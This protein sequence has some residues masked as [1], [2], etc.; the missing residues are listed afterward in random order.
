MP[1]GYRVVLSAD[2]I[3][4]R[5]VKS[6]QHRDRYCVDCTHC[7]KG[8]KS[9]TAYYQRDVCELRPKAP[10]CALPDDRQCYYAVQRY[11]AAC[12]KFNPR[13]ITNR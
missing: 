2:S 3:E 1:D 6:R 8:W 4:I 11:D 12:T 10:R 13:T 7:V 9:P 5:P